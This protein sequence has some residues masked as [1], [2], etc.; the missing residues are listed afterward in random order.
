[1]NMHKPIDTAAK[2]ARPV[3]LAIDHAGRE[4]ELKFVVDNAAFKI[5]QS[6]PQFG[7]PVAGPA[8]RRLLTVYFDTEAGD[9]KRNGIALRARRVR[10]GYLMGLKWSH[11]ANRSVFERGEIEVKTRSAKPDPRI[12][13][14]ETAGSIAQIVAD[15]PLAQVFVSDIRRS[16]R[17]VDFAGSRIDRKSVV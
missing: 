14:S 4:H 3:R 12:F 15:R 17:T 5:A 11:G 2:G 9:L 13:D 16:V 6:L 8:W 10:G 1:M 7:E